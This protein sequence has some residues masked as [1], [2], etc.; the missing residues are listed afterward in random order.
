MKP[1]SPDVMIEQVEDL[2][3]LIR[4]SFIEFQNRLDDVFTSK[5]LSNINRIIATGD[6]DSWHAA[7]A[8]RFAFQLFSGVNYFPMSAMK[9]LAYGTDSK[10]HTTS[11]SSLLIVGISAS[12]RS[13]RVVQS[14]QKAKSIDGEITTLAM[15]GTPNSNLAN[16]SDL[17]YSTHIPDFGPSPGIRTYVASLIGGYALAL[18]LAL[19]KG[20]LSVSEIQKER[21]KIVALADVIDESL[22]S[23]K[24][25]AKAAASSLKRAPFFSFVGSGPSFATA[26]FSA[27]KVVEAAGIF[28]TAQDLEEWVHIEHHA[29]PTD[30]PVCVIVPGGRSH[31]RAKQL[32]NLLRLIGHPVL[33]VA[34][35]IDTETHSKA[36]FTFSI[37][38][39]VSEEYSPLVYHLPANYFA[40]Y[41]AKAL[42][43]YPF[44]QDNVEIKRRIN[45]VTNQIYDGK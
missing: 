13:T 15:V 34:P 31:D 40:C 37:K 36:D 20:R 25:T 1:F 45:S 39:N 28:S 32:I 10:P 22:E 19:V 16:V 24:T 18:R 43:R 26:Y 17:V 23:V 38:G 8:V 7:M 14:M 29:Y 4:K 44:M 2:G 3:N 5:K 42:N 9:Y 6:G 30:T 12:G 11:P 35:D 27:A 41:L 33:A 21:D